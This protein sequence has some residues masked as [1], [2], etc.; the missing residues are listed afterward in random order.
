MNSHLSLQH[1]AHDCNAAL[2]V[3][4]AV[5]S[6]QQLP[7]VP[8]CSSTHVC[9]HVVQPSTCQ[10]SECV[11]VTVTTLTCTFQPLLLARLQRLAAAP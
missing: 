8:E 11:G 7:K 1:A 10:I 6:L 5:L 4:Y 2:E 9:R 3:L